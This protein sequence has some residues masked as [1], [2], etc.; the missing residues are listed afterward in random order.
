MTSV[1]PA[2]LTWAPARNVGMDVIGDAIGGDELGTAFHEDEEGLGV[3]HLAGEVANLLSD[4][5]HLLEAVLAV[6]IVGQVLELGVEA[7]AWSARG[8]AG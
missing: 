8:V 3:D 4:G 6:L 1:L 7:C 5:Q 2:G